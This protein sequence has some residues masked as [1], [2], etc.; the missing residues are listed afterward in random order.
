MKH[1]TTHH[2]RG[3]WAETLALLWLTLKGYSLVKK[4]YKTQ[5]GEIDLIMRRGNV[6][7]FIEVKGR[8]KNADAAFA[9]HAKNQ[10][11]VVR[12]AQHFLAH[13]PTYQQ[14]QVRF[15]AVLIAWYRMPQHLAHAFGQT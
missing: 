8:A 3:L 6:L 13:H 4:R 7:A 5:V 11:R 9:I 12:A 10:S 1:Y 15:D 14:Y 2:R